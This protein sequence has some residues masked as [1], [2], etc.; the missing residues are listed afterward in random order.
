MKLKS[1]QWTPA[2]LSLSGAGVR[3]AGRLCPTIQKKTRE[4][5]RPSYECDFKVN[6]P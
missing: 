2:S 5:G 3:K 6:P 4:S 1:R